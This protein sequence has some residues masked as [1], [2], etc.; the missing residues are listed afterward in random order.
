MNTFDD[1][2][3][4]SRGVTLLELLTVIAIIAILFALLMP[5]VQSAKGRAQRV[6]CGNSL[7][8]IGLAYHAWAHEH[9]NALPF[10]V[11]MKSGGTLE[12]V[13]DG[14]GASVFRHFQV[15]SNDLVVPAL[16]VCPMDRR[17]TP[18]G[19]FG[20]LQNTNVSYLV[21]PGAVF[22]KADSALASDRNLRTSGRMTFHSIRFDSKSQVEWSPEIHAHRGNVLF[23]DG[24][25]EDVPSSAA[26]KSFTT[27]VREVL[28]LVPQ[29]GADDGPSA[30]QRSSE[31]ASFGSDVRIS[32]R[33]SLDSRPQP[34]ATNA[35]PTNDRITP[36]PTI[37]ASVAAAPAGGINTPSPTEA[38]QTTTP[39]ASRSDRTSAA[40]GHRSRVPRS[41]CLADC[42]CE[43]ALEDR[44]A[45]HVLSSAVSA[46]G[47]DHARS[48]PAPPASHKRRLKFSPK[49]LLTVD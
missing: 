48:V 13:T 49:L 25:V 46:H 31:L 28:L 47:P 15:L 8:Q 30:L 14:K 16:L 1:D 32:A 17:R 6:R 5:V 22:G 39:S 38:D 23:G 4:A 37:G 33:Q 40:Q 21:N 20:E 35:V 10:Q 44:R 3:K 27:G 12:F 7:R 45:I 24:H 18:A 29:P 9:E 26:R 43:M 36:L 2:S 11:S 19:D 41:R 42:I 34:R